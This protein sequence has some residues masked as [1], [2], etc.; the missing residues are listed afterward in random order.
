MSVSRRMLLPFISEG[1]TDSP[2]LMQAYIEEELPAAIFQKGY[3]IIPGVL[4][5]TPNSRNRILDFL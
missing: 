5:P 3:L 4:P 2:L 1:Q